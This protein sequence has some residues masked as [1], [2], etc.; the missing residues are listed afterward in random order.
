MAASTVRHTKARKNVNHKALRR[1]DK[2]AILEGLAPEIDIPPAPAV[3]MDGYR[4]VIQTQIYENYGAHNWDGKGECPQYWKAKGGNE[5]QTPGDYRITETTEAN[6]R[7]VLERYR[8]MIERK[9]C[10]YH[11]YIIGVNWYAPNEETPDERMRRDFIE[12][13]YK[14]SGPS[15]K[16]LTPETELDYAW[17]Q[18]DTVED[19]NRRLKWLRQKPSDNDD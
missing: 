14:D 1:A 9:S 11:E 19:H 5:Y 8:H 16:M 4:L 13:G 12:W 2:L 10:G 15:W 6:E 7:K 18:H 3:P 17:A